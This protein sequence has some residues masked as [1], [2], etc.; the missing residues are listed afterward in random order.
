MSSAKPPTG[1][2]QV[3]VTNCNNRVL[4]S[5]SKERKACKNNICLIHHKKR[6]TVPTLKQIRPVVSV[7][8]LQ[9]VHV[10]FQNVTGTL[11]SNDIA[12]LVRHFKLVSDL[13][14]PPIW[15]FH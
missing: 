12:Y 3:P 4:F 8:Q 9:I 2:R 6:Q 1:R 15:D 5:L 10:S 14:M 11:Q 7:K 13:T